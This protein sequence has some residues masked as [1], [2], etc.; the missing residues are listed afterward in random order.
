M[1]RTKLNGNKLR[2]ERERERE[3]EKERQTAR[4]TDKQRQRQPDKERLIYSTLG[5]KKEV[6]SEKKKAQQ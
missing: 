4:Q 5:I 3:K 2:G 6:Y 1:E